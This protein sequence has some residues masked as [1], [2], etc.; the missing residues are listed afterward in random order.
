[1]TSATLEERW[2]EARGGRIRYLVAG[3]GPPLVLVHGL[4][5]SAAN[6]CEL[7]PLLAP[8]HRV[9]IPDLPG[10][11]GSDPVRGALGLEPYVERI[12]ALMEHEGA[13]PAPV[14]GHSL[15]GLVAVRLALRRPE[16]VSAL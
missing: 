3:E 9:L 15:G 7:A 12:A 10:H 4:G 13:L 1:M 11:G 14:V 2:T 8:S 6:W 5:G 16:A